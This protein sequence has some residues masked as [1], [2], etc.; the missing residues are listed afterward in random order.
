MAGLF[1]LSMAIL[2]C[3]FKAHRLRD[4][5]FGSLAS[6]INDLHRFSGMWNLT[7]NKI[8]DFRACQS[9]HDHLLD[10]HILAALATELK[11]EDWNTFERKL[12]GE[13]FRKLIQKVESKFSNNLLV[14][15][16][17]EE[18][19]DQRDLVHE[20]AVLFLQHGLI[21]RRF[22]EALKTGDSGWVVHC[23]KHF[24]VY[25][26]NSNKKTSLPLY[27]AELINIIACLS[28]GFSPAAKKHWL[29][30][31]MVNISGSATGHRPCDLVGEY[32]IREM[33]R[34]LR[35]MLNPANDYF[36]RRVY[37]PQ[38]MTAKMV[39]QHI[40]KEIGAVQYYQHSSAVKADLDVRHIVE[41]LLQEKVFIR[42]LGRHC[43]QAGAGE[44]IEE[45][46]DLYGSGAQKLLEGTHLQRYK[47][48]MKK[49]NG[50]VA[51]DIELLENEILDI[52]A[53]QR[54]DE[55]EEDF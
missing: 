31:C 15:E 25:L 41:A 13:N 1:H 44:A 7:T 10:G 42:T 21:Y 36:H 4:T 53:A 27:R 3:I 12:E 34:R 5:D 30:Q 45:A 24:T 23:L 32:F 37:A 6:W 40:Y 8:K 35:H 18:S 49:A 2:A 26:N 52:D 54:E 20:N 9:F 48:K 55:E 46:V 50:F 51:E 19:M 14:W 22:T 28:H 39:K 17:R 33:K 38:V 29:N 43:Y 47:D 11:A 16:W